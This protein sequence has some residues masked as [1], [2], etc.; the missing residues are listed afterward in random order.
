MILWCLMVP[1]SFP[2]LSSVAETACVNK[3]N[4]TLSTETVW[5]NMAQE[6]P[7]SNM[8]QFTMLQFQMLQGLKREASTRFLTSDSLDRASSHSCDG[9]MVKLK[10][11][12]IGTHQMMQASDTIWGCVMNTGISSTIQTRIQEF[13]NASTYP[14][15]KEVIQKIQLFS[16]LQLHHGTS[17]LLLQLQALTLQS[18]SLNQLRVLRCAIGK[19]KFTEDSEYSLTVLP[20]F[21]VP[22]AVPGG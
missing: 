17:K 16:T 3:T 6:R 5:H 15:A 8:S 14:I 12:D 7:C 21:H 19:S 20:E 4:D 13:R 2:N 11:P 22:L 1:D 9:W 10:E 18:V